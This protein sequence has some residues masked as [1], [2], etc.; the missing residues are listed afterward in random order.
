MKNIFCIN[1][2]FL[3]I[4]LGCVPKP[5]PI[6]LEQAEQKLVVASQVIPN[7]VMVMTLSRSMDT[8]GFNSNND[9][10]T[11][12]V[13]DQL[14]VD[15]GLVTISYNG[16]TDTL[17]YSGLP[18]VFVSLNT[19]QYLN[20]TYYLKAKDYITGMEVT[21]TAF[22]LNQVNFDTVS[23][24]IDSNNFFK[25][26]TVDFTFDD[27]S[28]ETNWYMVNFYAEADTGS[29]S[30][31]VDLSENENIKQETI[32]LSDKNFTNSNVSVSHKLIDWEQDTVFVSISNISEGY[33]N[34]LNARLRS[35]NLFTSIVS[36]P[37][38][39]PTNIEGGYGFFTTHV[40]SLRT[41]KVD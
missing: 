18:G 32:I 22:M 37:V 7:S 34:Y 40:P 36:E 25:E 2:V 5:I 23:A 26:I 30:G 35:G 33:Y 12:E 41:V 16:I 11:Q 39:H 38:N 31:G 9:S 24:S 6:E 10:L 13:L 27:P 14:L 19:P 21:S 4:L 3:L 17:F 8:K 1:F 28:Q 20:T 15:S 29:T